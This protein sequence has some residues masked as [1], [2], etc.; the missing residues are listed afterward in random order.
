[1][2]GSQFDRL[3]RRLAG[4]LSR[5]W[6]LGA[7]L[8][9][10]LG[11]LFNLGDAE[12]KQK[13]K[14]GKGKKK[15]GKNKNKKGQPGAAACTVNGSGTETSTDLTVTAKDLTLNSSERLEHETGALVS[16]TT[17]SQKQ[18]VLAQTTT[19]FER[20]GITRTE[21]LY[22]GAYQGISRIEFI[23]DGSTTSGTIDGRAIIPFPTGASL[24]GLQFQDGQPAPRMSG[25]EQ[26]D[27]QVSQL[28]ALAA[29]QAGSC[30]VPKS[31]GGSGGIARRHT[32]VEC[33]SCLGSCAAEATVC[34]IEA[35]GPCAAVAAL[36]LWGAPAC[37]A[38]CYAAAFALCGLAALACTD[39][40]ARGPCCAVAC[41]QSNG[42]TFCCEEGQT[43][44]RPGAC[45]PA[46][47]T[48]CGGQ[49]CCTSGETC[50]PDGSCCPSGRA[51]GQTCCGPLTPCCGGRCCGGICNGNTCC[52]AGTL[53]CGSGCCDGTCCNGSCCPSGRQCC[54]GTC[55]QSGFACLN[56]QC[57][58]V[59]N[60][61][62]VPCGTTCCT[63]GRSCYT[64]PNG[65]RVC[66]FGPC[67]N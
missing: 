28:Y 60:A 3:T 30:A 52:D 24:E 39:I 2:D 63:G 38:G 40:C 49:N 44:L 8:S 11:A 16:T 26:L 6:A 53:P 27:Q 45:C 19:R 56:N 9:G 62:E 46:G 64:C 48:P 55:C 23:S 22:G 41:H 42:D 65:A 47:L 21:I 43:C 29:A 59:C 57:V 17:I 10:A 12:A 15:K 67:I 34:A 25:N 32:S 7:G 5:R 35:K 54:N 20:N 31:N 4:A 37:F 36:C 18:T 14:K 58:Q 1:M 13:K 51:C 66:R 61:G 33:L 50:L